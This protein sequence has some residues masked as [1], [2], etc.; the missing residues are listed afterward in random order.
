MHM[1]DSLCCTTETKTVLW[2]N[3]NPIKIYLKKS[4]VIESKS[5]SLVPSFQWKTLPLFHYI[6]EWASPFCTDCQKVCGI[7]SPIGKCCAAQQWWEDV[8]GVP[9]TSWDNIMISPYLV[10]PSRYLRPKVTFFL[11]FLTVTFH[12]WGNYLEM[13]AFFDS[14]KLVPCWF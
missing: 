3:Y 11:L 4:S 8:P 7:W 14:H 6:L 5:A 10:F 12:I 13:M 2:S 9:R 1:A